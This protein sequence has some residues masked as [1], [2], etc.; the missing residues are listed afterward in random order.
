[1]ALDD[2]HTLGLQLLATEGLHPATTVQFAEGHWPGEIGDGV[3]LNDR[4]F[5]V[6]EPHLRA[7][8]RG[9]TP[10]HRYGVFELPA[11]DATAL[12]ARLRSE[13][14]RM[15]ELGQGASSLNLMSSLADWLEPRC[16]GR[17]LSVLGY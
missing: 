7:S 4:A 10:Q 11:T 8:S 15:R 12:V 6:I 5:D 16:D 14:C 9:W 13:V 1:M 17:H 3:A 2:G